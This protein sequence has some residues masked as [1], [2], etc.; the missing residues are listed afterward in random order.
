V[1]PSLRVLIVEDSPDDA[2]RIVN[3]LQK[4]GIDPLWERIETAD[5]MRKA[6]ADASWDIILS[7]HNLSKFAAAEVLAMIRPAGPDLPFFV[8]SGTIGEEAAVEV[9]R[10]GANDFVLMATDMVGSVGDFSR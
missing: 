3:A 8:V 9:M 10:A 2:E 6:L 1:S 5:D 7:D 4:A